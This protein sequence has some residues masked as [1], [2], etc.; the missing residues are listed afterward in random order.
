MP[1][2]FLRQT[3]Y[4]PQ[5]LYME[6]SFK[7]KRRHLR[8]I[9]KLS[10]ALESE[11]YRS[12]ES[13]PMSMREGLEFPYGKPWLTSALIDYLQGK[14]T[15]II[16]LEGTPS[17]VTLAS[18]EDCKLQLKLSPGRQWRIVVHQPVSQTYTM[19]GRQPPRLSLLQSSA[20]SKRRLVEEDKPSL[21]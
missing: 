18:N 17:T 10:V 21:L 1:S 11:F 13:L 9:R 16:L 2:E 7:C 3:L 15:P 5:D 20:S 4:K 6:P 14:H 19:K 12:V 8:E